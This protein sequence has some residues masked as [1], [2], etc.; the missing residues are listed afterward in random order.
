MKSVLCVLFLLLAFNA[1]AEITIGN[2]HAV[3]ADQSIFRGRE[4][5]SRVS[6]LSSLEISDVI[7]FKNDTRGEVVKE[8]AQLKEL[9][10]QS[11][12]IPFRWKGFESVKLACE[13]LIEGIQILKAVKQNGGKTF[14][15]CTA[16]EDR[17]GAL[18]GLYRMMSEGL[19]RDQALE[20]EMCPRGYSDGNE[21]KPY[22]VTSSIHK[23]LTPIFFA[24]ARQIE[25]GYLSIDKLDRNV[26]KTLKVYPTNFKCRP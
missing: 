11:H 2:F 23:E 18:A 5:K 22:Y 12:H 1:K 17:T 26:C 7:I 9:G 20:E 16:G 4:P 10:I 13:Q 8:L 3:D 14:F 19:T 15:H 25:R 21:H 24:M 6:E